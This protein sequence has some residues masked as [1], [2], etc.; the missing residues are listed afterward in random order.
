MDQDPDPKATAK[1]LATAVWRLVT[2]IVVI[3]L[4][5]GGWI[6]VGYMDG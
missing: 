4:L 1:V 2:P 6:L 3:A 5:I